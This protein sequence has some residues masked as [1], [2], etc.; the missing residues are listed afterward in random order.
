RELRNQIIAKYKS[1]N[2][3]IIRGLGVILSTIKMEEGR[4]KDM[5]FQVYKDLDLYNTFWVFY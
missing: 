3:A 4:H 2:V 1:E 5:W